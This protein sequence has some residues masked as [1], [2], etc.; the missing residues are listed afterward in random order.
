M[1]SGEVTRVVFIEKWY[2]KMVG[3]KADQNICVLEHWPHFAKF[4]LSK[5]AIR[6]RFTV[7]HPDNR[8]VE[9]SWVITANVVKDV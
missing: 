2:I 5:R 4:F 8:D 6:I 7:V 1:N 9:L 3:I